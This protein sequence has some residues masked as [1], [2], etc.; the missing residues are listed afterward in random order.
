MVPNVHFYPS[1]TS[2]QNSSY[3][4]QRLFYARAALS[5]DSF[6][7][8]DV[9]GSYPRAKTDPNLTNYLRQPRCSD[10]TPTHPGCHF[11]IFNAQ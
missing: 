9:P 6:E 4:A 10:G 2:A 1:E 11:Q 8:K 7:E 3:A 5:G